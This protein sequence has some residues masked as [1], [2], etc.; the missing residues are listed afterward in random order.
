[1]AVAGVAGRLG[2]CL[3]RRSGC[4]AGL[5]SS[6]ELLLWLDLEGFSSEVLWQQGGDCTNVVVRGGVGLPHLARP[7]DMLSHGFCKEIG[8]SR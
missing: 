7:S 5:P 8:G 4:S 6:A 1:M 3:G 2:L